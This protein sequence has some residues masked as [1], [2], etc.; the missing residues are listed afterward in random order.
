VL[1]FALKVFARMNFRAS[2][3]LESGFAAAHG[4]KALPYRE[5]GLT[6]FEAAPRKEGIDLPGKAEPFR[7]VLRQSRSVRIRMTL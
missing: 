2:L 6:D 1:G 3:N 5:S 7:H 4:G